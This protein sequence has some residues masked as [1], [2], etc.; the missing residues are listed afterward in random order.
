MAGTRDSEDIDFQCW[1]CDRPFTREAEVHA[2]RFERATR[3]IMAAID[4]LLEER[5]KLASEDGADARPRAD[6]LM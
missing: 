1:F 6:R 4:D 2:E 3:R 5:Y